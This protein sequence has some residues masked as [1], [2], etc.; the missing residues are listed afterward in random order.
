MPAITQQ[1]EGGRGNLILTS[2]DEEGAVG[3]REDARAPSRDSQVVPVLLNQID[4]TIFYLRRGFLSVRELTSRRM[5]S[6]ELFAPLSQSR[7]HP[8]TMKR[9]MSGV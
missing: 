7:E 2:K 6:I 3:M 8:P 1:R 5:V 4:L 9:I